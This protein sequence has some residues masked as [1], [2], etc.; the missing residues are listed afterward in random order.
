M[1]PF[2]Y[3]WL[4]SSPTPPL[5]LNPEFNVGNLSSSKKSSSSS[6]S[7]RQLLLKHYIKHYVLLDSQVNTSTINPHH[8]IPEMQLIASKNCYNF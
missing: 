5:Y 3:S 4:I 6:V 1:L 7:F 2:P 8:S